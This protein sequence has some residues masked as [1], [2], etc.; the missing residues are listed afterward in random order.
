MKKVLITG[1]RSGIGLRTGLDL[2]KL[3]YNV[4]LSVHNELELKELD[5]K[6][7]KMNSSIKVIKL[8]I[9]NEADLNKI[10][11]L[12]IDI[13]VNNAGVGI[14]GSLINIDTDLI[15]ENFKTNVIGT[16]KVSRK[17]LASL[18]LNKKPG[19][20]IFIGSLAGIIPISYMASYSITKAAI[21]IMSKILKKEIK[22]TKMDTQVKLI[23]PGIY[24]TG[25]NDFMFDFLENQESLKRKQI[26][27][28][29][30]K[31][32]LKGVSKTI[33]KSIESESNKL[34]Y[35]TN[36]FD[37]LLIKVYNLFFS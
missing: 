11:D 16:L 1:A 22:L 35:R 13:L 7:Q 9:L 20:I 15:V 32:K 18:Y 3:G 19:K 5:K 37:S 33:V 34:I 17:F 8:D 26:F 6:L 21:H 4:V 30:G 27:K 31:D 23:E 28:L 29:I 25:F 36:I 24:N 10:F 2:E 12:D 14:G